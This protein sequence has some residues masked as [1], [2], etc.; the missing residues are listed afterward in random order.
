MIMGN[1]VPQSRTRIFCIFFRIADYISHHTSWLFSGINKYSHAKIFRF[2]TCENWRIA[3][4]YGGKYNFQTQKNT[5]KDYI[6]DLVIILLYHITCQITN[7][8]E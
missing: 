3:Y 7:Q 5:L 1:G 4:M 8:G 6:V 2:S